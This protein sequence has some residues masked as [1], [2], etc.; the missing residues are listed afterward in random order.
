M[1]GIHGAGGHSAALWPFA[2]LAADEGADIMFPDMPIYGRTLEPRPGQVRYRDW[3]DLLCDLVVAERTD[4]PRPLVLFGAS[5]GGMMAYE[6][7]S[8]TGQVDVVLATCLLDT[9][10]PA[11]RAAAARWEIAGRV[12]PTVLP[13]IARVAGGL[14]PPVK[15]LVRMNSMSNDPGL[16]ALCRSDP[17]GGGVRVPLGFLADWFAYRH[18][19]PEQ[20]TAA[21]VTLLHP[22]ADR[23]TPPELSLRFLE[24][25]AAPTHSVLL[26]NCG[27]FPIE[28]P[29]L[30]RMID[31]AR[32]VI[33][34]VVD[35]A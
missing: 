12:A 27:H 21:P 23:W 15:W 2:S 20:F 10:D 32:S 30:T 8:R 26:E 31:A 25:I 24:R 13:P 33:S 6:V 19:P 11:A 34:E 4:D 1:L 28:E 3:I 17:R 9:T 5:M 22:A 14:R 7:A 29:G 16:T 35:R 18:T